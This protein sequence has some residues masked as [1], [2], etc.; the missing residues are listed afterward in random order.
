M[1]GSFPLLTAV[2]DGGVVLFEKPNKALA[3]A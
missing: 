3:D 2:R 1:I